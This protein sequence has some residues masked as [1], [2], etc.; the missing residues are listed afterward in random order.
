MNMNDYQA[1]AMRTCPKINDWAKIRNGCYGMNG[2]AGECIDILKKTEFQGHPFD[3]AKMVDEL[4]DVLWYV[5]QTAHGLGIPLSQ[6]A[7]R[8]IEKLKERY[9]DG[10]DAERSIHR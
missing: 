4:G 5:A 2:E 6:V 9:P 3:E 7:E 1:L 8:N 10:F